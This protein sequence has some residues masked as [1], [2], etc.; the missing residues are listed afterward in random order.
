M[1]KKKSKERT[2][3]DPPIRAPS[4][5]NEFKFRI[6]PPWVGSGPM[7]RPCALRKLDRAAATGFPGYNQRRREKMG[8]ELKKTAHHVKNK[9]EYR[10]DKI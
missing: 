7:S 4:P 8:A 5:E 2:S 9:T 1:R 3:D 6:K 10:S